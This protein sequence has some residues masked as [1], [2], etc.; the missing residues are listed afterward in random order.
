VLAVIDADA[1]PHRWWLRDLVAP[2]SD[3]RVG[4][5]TGNRWY[6]PEHAN[7]GSLVRYLWNV[8][9]VVQVWFNE[10]KSTR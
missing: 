5:A 10:M 3:P 1:V 7:W 2:L 4:V 8:G 6:M 9:A